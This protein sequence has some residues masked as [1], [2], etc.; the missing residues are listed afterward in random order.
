MTTCQIRLKAAK[1]IE[2]RGHAKRILED[3]HGRVCLNGAI[4]LALHGDPQ[5]GPDSTRIPAEHKAAQRVFRAM[6]FQD[7]WDAVMWNNA[8]RRRK[9]DVLARLREGC[10]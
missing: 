2:K 1:V 7:E 9:R 10:P 6:G 4:N 5:F 3:E 8:K